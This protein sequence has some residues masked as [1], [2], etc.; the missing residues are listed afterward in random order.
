VRLGD[1]DRLDRGREVRARAHPVPDPVEVV[2][3]VGLELAQ[4]L[5]VHARGTVIGS[6]SLEC[7]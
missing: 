6:D 1:L 4:C 5:V 7:L 2:L 3:Q